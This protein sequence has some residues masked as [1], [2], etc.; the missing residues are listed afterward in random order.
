MI[1]ATTCG[2]D[3]DIVDERSRLPHL[4]LYWAQSYISAFVRLFGT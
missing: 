3:R 4:D 1:L 2:S